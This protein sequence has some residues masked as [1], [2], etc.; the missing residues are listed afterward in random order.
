[1]A[2]ISEAAV[3]TRLLARSSCMNMMHNYRRNF[4][5]FKG[6]CGFVTLF[7]SQW[8]HLCCL[9]DNLLSKQATVY[10]ITWLIMPRLELRSLPVPSG[11]HLTET[12]QRHFLPA[13]Q[14]QSHVCVALCCVM[15]RCSQWLHCTLELS[16]V[17][18]QVSWLHLFMAAKRQQL[19]QRRVQNNTVSVCSFP[20]WRPGGNT[21][22]GHLK[23]IKW[24][25]CPITNTKGFP[26][27][28]FETNLP[29]WEHLSLLVAWLRIS[30]ER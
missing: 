14:T 2:E 26:I 8:Q 3:T 4:H 10:G 16:P 17:G 13:G 30:T 1:M 15:S 18:V 24:D 19:L 23:A 12:E 6:L 27:K 11:C 29:C 21:P 22:T 7:V 9:V 5:E 20:L 28:T 25:F